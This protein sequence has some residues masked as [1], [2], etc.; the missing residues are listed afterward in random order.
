MFRNQHAI[1]AVPAASRRNRQSMTQQR[2]V[3][4]IE[5][6]LEVIAS[7]EPMLRFLE[8]KIPEMNK[9]EKDLKHISHGLD[10]LVDDADMYAAQEGRETIKKIYKIQDDKDISPENKKT[11]EEMEAVKS[12]QINTV[13]SQ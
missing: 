5:K 2:S 7:K 13:Q 11:L 10:H 1:Q 9:V 3:P 6:E 12:K 4:D 8:K